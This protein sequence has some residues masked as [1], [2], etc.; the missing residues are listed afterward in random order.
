MFVG[1]DSWVTPSFVELSN[2][3]AMGF[4]GFAPAPADSPFRTQILAEYE[5]VT[6]LNGVEASLAYADY[7]Y[8]TVTTFGKLVLIW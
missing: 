7:G 6:G 8:D 2:G 5:A 4:V 1:T 3:A